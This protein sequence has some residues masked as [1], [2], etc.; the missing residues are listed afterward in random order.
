M[1][2][3]T[4]TPL[5]SAATAVPHP[6][7]PQPASHAQLAACVEPLPGRQAPWPEHSA[8]G[9]VPAAFSSGAGHAWLALQETLQKKGST[10][11]LCEDR[12]SV[13]R[14]CRVDNVHHVQPV[15]IP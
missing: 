9:S 5:L 12:L 8:S 2:A 14:D 11:S 10:G 7:S 13:G 3:S 1:V 4:W 15:R 6:S